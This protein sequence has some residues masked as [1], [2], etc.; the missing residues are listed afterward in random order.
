MGFMKLVYIVPV[1][2]A[3]LTLGAVW[4][5]TQT[6][7]Q[8]SLEALTVPRAPEDTS[9][10]G[11]S[12]ESMLNRRKPIRDVSS[13]K[14]RVRARGTCVDGNGKR[15]R[16]GQDGYS[17]CLEQAEGASP[18]TPAVRAHAQEGVGTAKVHF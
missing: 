2:V 4:S 6:N 16:I 18:V 14:A 17:A 11:G 9:A 5:E 7:A 15:F 8:D 10:V 1:L 13:K 12:A 3:G